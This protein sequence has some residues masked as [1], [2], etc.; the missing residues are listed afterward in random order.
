MF[1]DGVL[2]MATLFV[3]EREIRLTW[4]LKRDR[5]QRHLIHWFNLPMN[6]TVILKLILQPLEWTY[7]QVDDMFV[8]YE[9]EHSRLY[10]VVSK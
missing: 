5:Y 3:L 8:E 9:S 10:E 2:Y 1:D 6:D 4:E 7:E